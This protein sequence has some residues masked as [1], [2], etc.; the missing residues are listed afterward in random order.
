[1]AARFLARGSAVFIIFIVV[2]KA[3]LFL[4]FFPRFGFGAALAIQAYFGEVI[5]MKKTRSFSCFLLH[6]VRDLD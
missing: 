2:K 3:G 5:T 6:P 4:L 1:M